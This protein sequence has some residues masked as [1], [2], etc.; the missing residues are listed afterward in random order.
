MNTHSEDLADRAH[1]PSS[2]QVSAHG[3]GRLLAVARGLALFLG[4]FSLLNV[5]GRI[6]VRGF[7]ANLWC[8]DLRPLPQ[9]LST[10]ALAVAAVFLVAY[11][12]RPL[13]SHW[14]RHATAVV[15]FC[16]F[17][18]AA[19][20]AV[21]YYVL[22]ERG[23]VKSGTLVPLSVLIAL[24]FWVML[25]AVR[26]QNAR[27]TPP[28]RAVM[29]L[30]FLAC[31]AGFPMA[32]MY[33]F[34]KTDYSRPADAIVVFGAGVYAD[35]TPSDA[36]KDR[37]NTACQLYRQGLARWMV[38]SGGPGMG[39]V[40]ETDA[41]RA[42]ALKQGVPAEAIVVDPQGI[43]TRATVEN[44]EAMF[45]QLDVKRVLA[46]SHFYHLPRIKMTYQRQGLEVY[47]VPARESY[48]LTAMPY[49]MAR[50]VAAIWAYYF[51]P[52]VG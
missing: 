21:N 31:S 23:E 38:L 22:L 10:P 27:Q 32:Q 39:S 47:T 20:N 45:R 51:H 44:T 40:S 19:W 18:A 52:L 6:I 16:L 35:G 24:A 12:L 11:A 4:G 9:W 5:L 41:M 37:M 34:G 48:F 42:M 7:D 50:E 28:R 13:M 26:G 36:L 33:F 29:A 14:R 1:K 15:T 30:V 49:Y 2:P 3:G 8:I 46:V 43:N 25:L 17:L